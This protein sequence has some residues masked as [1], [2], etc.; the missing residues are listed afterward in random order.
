[1]KMKIGYNSRDDRNLLLS[2]LSPTS[3]Y[4]GSSPN[5]NGENEGTDTN[6]SR[7]AH[8]EEYDEDS[9]TS[10]PKESNA[11]S[12]SDEDE[13]AS[14]P[15]Y[16]K[17]TGDFEASDVVGDNSISFNQSD[18]DIDDYDDAAI[19]H[20]ED[21]DDEDYSID[22][23]SSDSDDD[24]DDD[25]EF[26]E[27]EKEPAFKGRK[28]W[29]DDEVDSN[30]SCDADSVEEDD[31][32]RS[33][34]E[35]SQTSSTFDLKECKVKLDDILD[36]EENSNNIEPNEVKDD[37]N[38][39]GPSLD[40]KYNE[41]VDE[42]IEV[43]SSLD[44]NADTGSVRFDEDPEPHDLSP[45]EEKRY[46]I[47]R[48]E[49]QHNEIGFNL[50]LEKKYENQV[51]E[52]VAV[53]LS[54]DYNAD[55]GSILFGEDS[56]PHESHS[57]QSRKGTTPV[58]HNTE[59]KDEE[60][61][62]NEKV[63]SSLEEK[64]ESGRTLQKHIRQEPKRREHSEQP[65]SKT[66]ASNN[67]ATETKNNT[68]TPAQP[69]TAD[70]HYMVDNLFR[71]VD[72]DT[73]TVKDFVRS[74][75]EHFNLSKV[76]KEMKKMIKARL[77]DLIQG[78]VEPE[79]IGNDENTDDAHEA[80]RRPGASEIYVSNNTKTE[81][82]KVPAPV[83]PSTADLHDV[84]DN[85]FR[86][87]HTDTII[88]KDIVRSVADHFNLPK[89]GKGMKKMIKARLTD[90][91][92]GDVESKCAGND[93]NADDAHE[94]DQH[95]GADAVE[96]T[97]SIG[98]IGAIGSPQQRA[99][100]KCTDT[101]FS[102][103]EEVGCDESLEPLQASF[104]EPSAEAPWLINDDMACGSEPTIPC[105]VSEASPEQS[106]FQRNVSTESKLSVSKHCSPQKCTKLK[107]FQHQQ[108]FEQ[109]ISS[110]PKVQPV[111]VHSSTPK[112]PIPI[113]GEDNDDSFL[114]GTLFQ[115][116]SPDFSIKSKTPSGKHNAPDYLMDKMSLSNSNGDLMKSRNIVEKGKWSLGSEIGAG[117]F[118]RVYMGM[119][120]I[121]GSI[122][123]VKVLQIPSD[124]KRAIVEDLQREIDLMRSLKH[125]N[126]VRYFGAEVGSKNTL[127]IF[128][129][130]M[131]GC[132]AAL[133]KKFGTFSIT[134]V[135]SYVTQI[136]K[137]LDY[138]H[139]H[140]IIHRDIKGG[141]ILVSSDGA[142]KLADFGASKR[143]EALGAESDEME[144]TMRGT[145][146]FMAPEVF[147]EK[148]GSKADIWSVG[149]VIY[150][151][152]TGSPP[153]KDMGFNSPVALFMHLKS[154]NSPPQLKHCDDLLLANILS[155]CFQRE[156]SMRPS[157]S[158]LLND[159]F[160][161]GDVNPTPKS[162]DLMKTHPAQSPTSAEFM[163]SPKSTFKSPL[164]QIPENEALIRNDSLCYSLTLQSPLP[165]VN[166][167]A[168]T[169][170][171][172]DWAS[173]CNDGT[174]CINANEKSGQEE[175]PFAKCNNE[176][177]ACVTEKSS[178]GTNPFAK[179][180][181][182]NAAG[183]VAYEQSAKVTNPFANENSG[184][185]TNPFVHKK[186]GKSGNPFASVK[187]GKRVNP[188]AK[189]R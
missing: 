174:D 48:K 66:Y 156:P 189:S 110:E 95:A 115:N 11:T 17:S 1:V 77:T 130:I 186:S 46:N 123:A 34:D 126:I 128:Q 5:S 168:D 25:F 169:S 145:P 164:N 61:V 180:N 82:I 104:K 10:H 6:C 155:R 20:G 100:D 16:V 173:K 184:H 106:K 59:E 99:D 178:K 53:D 116:L 76:G 70:I 88:V 28:K 149:G 15:S 136:L 42:E 18:G 154:H 7:S 96:D 19:Y 117:S 60:R 146:Y 89:V 107:P 49:D 3:T 47:E 45:E 101:S 131:Q 35:E 141:N 73:V 165:K 122:M 124:N 87:V 120:A 56:E 58:K 112:S 79:C 153:W 152:V 135:K 172:P 166:T 103:C 12:D 36:E 114:S 138:L 139:S 37:A 188:F 175:K 129:E 157:A 163:Q 187:S 8:S 23:E 134:V 182:E 30:D 26:E 75:A 90:L 44:D 160:L 151:M 14:T 148:Y 13:G 119:N 43:D 185:E 29:E 62:D 113:V 159:D 92:E 140:G 133:L 74:V 63:V 143:V 177:A 109:D 179:C 108:T 22:A 21:T 9:D 69:S 31:D 137:G 52:E 57:E 39:L 72:T 167:A 121:N 147:E 118:G 158:T 171:W 33:A 93:E 24:D 67:T 105:S 144:L 54:L 84:V 142:I 78:N 32:E 183:V 50:S 181:K 80:F 150:Q 41:Q 83:E 2:P 170:E 4:G 81:R 65:L 94:S 27:S 125:P 102:Q 97:S 64:I 51:D 55:A 162:S 161:N 68:P 91:I 71:E 40:K 38:G 111:D 132:I 86:E 127:Y 176:N 85:L 98:N